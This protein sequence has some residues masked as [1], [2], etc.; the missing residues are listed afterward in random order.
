[1]DKAAA[2]VAMGGYNTFCEILSFDKRALIVPRTRPRLEQYIRAIE[3]ERLGLVRMLERLRRARARRADGDGALRNLSSQPRAFAKSSC[4]GLLDGL[5]R[6]QERLTSSRRAPVPTCR[7]P[8]RPNNR[9]DVVAART[10]P[11]GSPSSSRA[12]RAC[13]RPSS[14]RKSWRSK[15][16]GASTRNLVAAPSDRE[17]PFIR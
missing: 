2:I 11:D 10:S 14:R 12:I 17:A 3:A 16:R 4:P 8:R 15:Q 9:P 6:M 13:P 5:D 7:P 1:M